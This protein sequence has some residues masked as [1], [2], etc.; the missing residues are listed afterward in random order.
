MKKM[1]NWGL[2][3]VYA[4]LL[5]AIMRKTRRLFGKGCNPVNY[6]DFIH[7]DAVMNQRNVP[8]RRS[9]IMVACEIAPV[10]NR[11]GGTMMR[12]SEDQLSGFAIEMMVFIRFKR[13]IYWRTSPCQG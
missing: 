11:I 3:R 7:R 8:A 1:N 5:K 2:K 9:C 13:W 4:D 10:K 12:A 6:S